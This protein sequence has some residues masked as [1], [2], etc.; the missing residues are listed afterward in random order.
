MVNYKNGKIYKIINENNEII[1]I[2]STAQ[3]LLCDRYYSHKFKS[4]NH[5][6]ILIENYSCNN[7]QELCSREQE[8]IEEYKNLY[9]KRRA[10]CSEEDKKKFK[11]EQNKKYVENNKKKIQDY[12]KEYYE[13]NVDKIKEQKKNISEEKKKEYYEK[14]KI[15]IKCEF[16][17]CEVR[18]QH[19]KRHQKTQ[20]CLKIQNNLKK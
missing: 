8:I 19:L 10:Y 4:P 1:Y 7:N 14:R 3:E 12:K 20:K 11:K 6:I 17:N 9:N 2:G 18:K 15:K 16:C 5:K 13:N